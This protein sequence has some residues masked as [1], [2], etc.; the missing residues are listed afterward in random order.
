[1][2]EGT[3]VK[4]MDIGYGAKGLFGKGTEL[5]N[6]SRGYGVKGPCPRGTELRSSGMDFHLQF[7]S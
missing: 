2:P 4:K 5:R 6:I 7:S 1:M 3:G